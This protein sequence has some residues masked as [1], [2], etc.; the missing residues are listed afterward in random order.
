MDKL[1]FLL[2]V[3]VGGAFGSM[4]RYIV[5]LWIGDRIE[6]VFPWG[7]WA[8]NMIGSLLIGFIFTLTVETT[9]FSTPMRLFLITG[10]LGGF[11]TFSSFANE[12]IL[13]FRQG[14]SL[15]GLLYILSTNLLGLLFVLIGG[16]IAHWILR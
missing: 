2:V 6:G 3:A 11:T 8:V 10:F 16:A 15:Y 7:T 1:Q 9:T 12:S 14:F 4:G 5:T 13:L